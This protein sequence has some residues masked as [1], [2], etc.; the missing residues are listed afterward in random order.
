MPNRI[1]NNGLDHFGHQEGESPV[2]RQVQAFVGHFRHAALNETDFVD[3]MVKLVK[4]TQFTLDMQEGAAFTFGYATNADGSSA[5]GE[6]VD[7]DPTIVGISTPYM[8]KMFAT[9]RSTSFVSTQRSSWTYPTYPVLVVDVSDHSRSFHPVALFV[10]SQQ[11]EELIGKAL[12][13]LFDKYKAITRE[14]RTI[15]YC[16]GDITK[17]STTP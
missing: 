9:R 5:I 15:R 3:D 1:Y 8:M 12:H 17:L 6:G 11:T 13:S 2:L 14:F 16:M 4:R 10:M 7:D